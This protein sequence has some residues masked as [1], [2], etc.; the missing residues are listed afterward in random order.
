MTRMTR[1]ESP[2]HPSA[3]QRSATLEQ[4]RLHGGH[5]LGDRAHR[6]SL[7]LRRC[8]DAE[9]RVG[10][11]LAL[12]LLTEGEE[13]PRTIS[14]A[15]SVWVE[16]VR[17]RDEML[18][19][20]RA[21]RHMGA[22]VWNDL[23]DCRIPIELEVR[24][25]VRFEAPSSLELIWGDLEIRGGDTSISL[26]FR[27]PTV[28]TS[29]RFDWP[30]IAATSRSVAE[31][32]NGASESILTVRQAG[33]AKNAAT[34]LWI[35]HQVDRSPVAETEDPCPRRTRLA[36]RLADGRHFVLDAIRGG[37]GSERSQGVC[38]LGS[39]E[40][41]SW[42][43]AVATLEP[44]RHWTSRRTITAFP[45]AWRITAPAIALSIEFHPTTD[46]QEVACFGIE[47]SR[48]DGVGRIEG[49]IEG[50]SVSTEARLRLEGDGVVESFRAFTH[51]NSR[52]IYDRI[53]TAVPRRFDER[54]LSGIVGDLIHP[55]DLDHEVLSR[56][57]CDPFWDL[58]DRGGKHWR[59][60]A[61][62]LLCESLSIPARLDPLFTCLVEVFHD[63]CLIVDDIED[64]SATRRGG[65]SIHLVHGLGTA[66]NAANACYFLP[67]MLLDDPRFGLSIEQRAAGHAALTRYL[68]ASHLGQALDLGWSRSVTPD[69]L[70]RRLDAGFDRQIL[71]MYALK[72]GAIAAAQVELILAIRPEHSAARPVL[73]ATL[74][75][76]TQVFQ[77]TDDILNFTGG[78]GWTRPLGEDLAHGKLTW[79]VVRA[80]LMLEGPARDRLIEI[81]CDAELRNDPKGRAEGLA[82]VTESGA[83]AHARAET[84]KGV[85]RIQKQYRHDL[86]ASLA[87]TTLQMT[88]SGLLQSTL[89]Y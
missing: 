5:E 59:P 39:G 7:D 65:P 8:T 71:A 83:I 2:Q 47:R 63:A 21:D 10:H 34:S 52:A 49:T 58:V 43:T 6:V 29:I 41:N 68:A 35:E 30:I 42:S 60:I 75:D 32:A 86:R 33:E 88:V 40:A 62:Q 24:D 37:A 13:R 31:T 87:A 61:V 1:A 3:S 36:A 77:I 25:D 69:E 28:D 56:E 19:E 84:R 70:R 23:D 18:M 54:T 17:R 27:D 73:I 64:G 26:A 51:A 4:W 81:L 89:D 53:S 55:A 45:I 14:R 12:S 15:D 78:P 66:I 74:R 44:I 82:L 20:G 79:V 46:D 76:W 67:M 72:S 9:G 38:R 48:W 50:A 57:I 85:Q 80:L 16:M 11:A 22:A